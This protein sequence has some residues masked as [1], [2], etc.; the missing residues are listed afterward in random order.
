MLCGLLGKQ[1]LETHRE[2]SHLEAGWKLEVQD[3]ICLE[4]S[5]HSLRSPGTTKF[6]SS[7]SLVFSPSWR[8]MISIDFL[9]ILPSMLRTCCGSRLGNASRITL[10]KI[11][12]VKGQQNPQKLGQNHST[13]LHWFLSKA[14]NPDSLGRKHA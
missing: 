2:F 8:C 7:R 14:I 5:L 12:H 4:I 10:K 6:R 11:C 3:L 13:M 1:K 9:T